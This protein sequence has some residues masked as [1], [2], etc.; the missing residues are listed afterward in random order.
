LFGYKAN[1]RCNIK[2]TKYKEVNYTEPIPSVRV[3]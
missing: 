1:N 3:P 2:S